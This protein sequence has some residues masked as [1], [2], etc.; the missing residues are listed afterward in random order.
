MLKNV[1]RG[2]GIPTI[3]KLSNDV[4]ARRRRKSISFAPVTLVSRIILRC[5]KGRHLC[6]QRVRAASIHV[7]RVAKVLELQGYGNRS[8]RKVMNG[9][10]SCQNWGGARSANGL[11]LHESERWTDKFLILGNIARV[12]NELVSSMSSMS[13]NR[14]SIEDSWQS[15]GVYGTSETHDFISN[16]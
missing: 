4:L 13:S 5:V 15:W 2:L 1:G 11:G 6:E 7:T 10:T 9:L 3:T 16:V 14:L 12:I 8:L